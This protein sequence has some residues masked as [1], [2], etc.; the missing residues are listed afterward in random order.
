MGFLNREKAA[1]GFYERLERSVVESRT[2]LSEN[3]ER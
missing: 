2:I 1:R 3:C